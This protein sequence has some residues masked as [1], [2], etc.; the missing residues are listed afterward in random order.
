MILV[1][2][3]GHSPHPGRAP[4]G[5]GRVGRARRIEDAKRETAATTVRA[6]GSFSSSRHSGARRDLS[7]GRHHA[8]RLT[9]R[10]APRRGATGRERSGR[11]ARSPIAHLTWIDGDSLRRD[12]DDRSRARS[13]RA[14]LVSTEVK[15]PCREPSPRGDEPTSRTRS[16]E[17]FISARRRVRPRKGSA[18]H[19]RSARR[20]IDSIRMG[21]REHPS[22]AGEVRG[23]SCP[24][25]G[26]RASPPGPARGRP[27]ALS[28]E[29]DE[30]TI[31]RQG[32]A[33]RGAA[34]CHVA[35]DRPSSDGVS[36]GG[37]RIPN[38]FSTQLSIGV[39]GNSNACVV[40][41]PSPRAPS[42]FV[43]D[44]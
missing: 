37:S 20:R 15:S 2:R 26:A 41:L 30:L 14:P 31:E 24:G 28:N 22:F 35:R 17:R 36:G 25:R 11:G 8:C 13:L 38:R 3:E 44:L 1:G 5:S 23:A 21:A 29:A 40:S 16:S 39:R 9:T 18:G 32:C 10:D 6:S 33:A 4:P 27:S 34:R 43:D 19:D 12:D 7:A 42:A